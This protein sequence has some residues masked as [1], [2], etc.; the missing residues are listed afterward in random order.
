MV[1]PK[2]RPLEI[3]GQ[4]HIENNELGYTLYVTKNKKMAMGIFTSST[5]TYHIEGSPDSQYASMVHWQ[6]GIM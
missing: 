1:C 2:L 3:T 4:H 6:M 5:C